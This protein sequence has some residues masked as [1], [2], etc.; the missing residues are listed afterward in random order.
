MYWS[1][2]TLG[3]FSKNSLTKKLG[4][5]SHVPLLWGLYKA[6]TK[7]FSVGQV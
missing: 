4:R 1:T 5:Y 7:A 6:Y 2:L 3:C